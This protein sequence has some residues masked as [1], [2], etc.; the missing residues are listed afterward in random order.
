M[1]KITLTLSA[2]F[3]LFF[4]VNAQ[5]TETQK[6]ETYLTTK[7]E[8]TFTFQI[9]NDNQLEVLTQ[10]LSL[11]HYDPKTKIVKAWANAEQFRQFEELGIAFQVPKIENEVDES[12]IY[13]VRPLAARSAMSTLTFPLSSYP[14]YAEYAQQMQDF[15]DDYPTL[16]E[17]VS[18]GSTG[19]G[20]KEILFVRISDNIDTDEQE[21]KLMFTSSMHGDEIAGYPMMLSLINY[22]LTVYNTPTH[23]DFPRVQNLVENAEIWINPNANPDGTYHN[24]ASNTSVV[25]ARRGNGNNVDLNRNFPDNVAGPHSDGNAYQVETLAFMALA[26]AHNFVISA[27]FHGGTELVNYPFDNAYAA[28]YTHPDN[29]WFE[30]VGVEYATHCQTD[31]NAGTSSTPPYTN[32]PSYMTDDED[33]DASA[34]NQAWHNNY[35]L[36]PGVTH[37]A[38]WYRVY[39]GRQDYMNYYHHCKEVTIELSDQKILQESLLD[40]YWYYNRDALLDYLTQGT[41]GFRGLV[42]DANTNNP[43]E[44]VKV[45]VVAHDDYGS[46]VYTDNHGAYYR[47]IKGGNYILQFEAPCYQTFT[48]TSHSISDGNTLTLADVLLVPDATVP[49]GLTATNVSTNSATLGWDDIAGMAYG[50]RYREVGAPSW[51]TDTAT[52]ATYNLTGLTALTSYEFQV[53][54]NCGSF[55]SAYSNSEQFTTTDV[56]PCTGTVVSSFPYLETFDAGI[57]DWTQETGDDGNWSLNANGTQSN[58]TG[59]SNDITGNGNY[60]YTE[61]STS[62]LGSNASVI[63]TSPCYVLSGIPEAYFSFYYHMY[64]ADVGTLDLEISSDD[65]NNWT[66]IFSASGNLGNQWNTETIDLLSYLGQTVKFRFIGTT[67]GGWS[68]D[69]AIDQIGIGG[70]PPVTYCNSTGNTQYETGVTAVIFGSID[71]A[72]GPTKDVGYEDFTNIS[73]DVVQGTTVDLTVRVNTDGNYTAHAF[74]WIDWNK[75]GDFDDSGEEYD[76]GDITNVSDGALTTLPI[77]IPESMIFGSTRMRVSAQYNA[78]PTACLTNFDGEVEDYTVNVKF[79]GLLYSGGTWDP[80]APNGTTTAE[81]V[82]ILDGIYNPMIDISINDLIVNAGATININPANNL[83]V[84]GTI[85]VLNTGNLILNSNSQHFSS[86]LVDGSVTGSVKYS[87]HVTSNAGGNDIIAPPVSGE[88]FTSFISNNSNIFSNATQTLYL[89]GPFEK[90]L[91]D[92]GLYANTET[93]TLNAGKGYRAASTDNGTFTFEGSVTTGP[94]SIP[95]EKTGVEFAKWNMIGNPYTSYIKLE[96]FLMENLNELD[97][98]SVAIYGYDGDD[99]DGS[100]WTIWN[101]AFSDNNPGSLI[102]PGQGFF[103]SSKDGG[104]S[105]SFTPSMRTLGTSDD[106]MAGR[107]AGGLAHFILTMSSTNKMSKTD[108]YFK[109]NATLGLDIGYDAELFE[110]EPSTFSIYSELTE[111]GQDLNMAIQSIGFD[112]VETSTLIPI[113]INL[114]QGQQVS[115]GMNTSDIDYN[116]YFEDTFTNSITLLNDSDYNFTADTDLLGTGRFFLRFET[117]TLS[118]SNSYLNAVQVYNNSDLKQIIVDGE[119]IEDT[120]FV[121]YDIQGREVVRSNLEPNKSTHVI[122]ASNFAKGVYLVQLSDRFK[123]LSKKLILR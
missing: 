24:S 94:L 38:E 28:Q 10:N 71:N 76:L 65:G 88:T 39:G 47:P 32:K 122:D 106:F 25:Q 83:T 35:A 5:M 99:S 18:I 9:E 123:T 115:I 117:E 31:A 48:T 61:A 118:T 40:D 102:A 93:A 114:L 22:I 11:V 98:Q 56:I 30:H 15:E 112:D 36:S 13:D 120:L 41:Y 116:V 100:V 79:N 44:D 49:T 92:Y 67:G 8:L 91:N 77:V 109:E 108:I 4:H 1:K 81:N 72:D 107:I 105:V 34:G 69:I 17:K 95:I 68:S 63:L 6:A 33:W 86:L 75:D 3:V 43:I 26:D 58:N 53:R 60:F 27:N 19:Q 52:D 16:V 51:T 66:T 101:M 111:S 14:T 96:D 84:A 119:L 59:P 73:T 70:A 54:S 23:P 80:S 104:S 74:A 45:T 57:G 46:E 85:E 97:A 62:G 110:E 121:L 29:D 78:N 12:R 64:G 20:D 7:G 90:P 89:F 103:V 42:L 87:R 82:L 50:L 2:F 55:S 21:P 37:G 113:G